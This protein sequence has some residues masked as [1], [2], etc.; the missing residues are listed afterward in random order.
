MRSSSS[1]DRKSCDTPTTT[2][3]RV[4]SHARHAPRA[5][6]PSDAQ[7]PPHHR[8]DA[9]LTAATMATAPPSYGR[10]AQLPPYHGRDAPMPTMPCDAQRQVNTLTPDQYGKPDNRAL[11]AS[12]RRS[13]STHFRK[14][15]SKQSAPNYPSTDTTPRPRQCSLVC[16]NIALYMRGKSMILQMQCSTVS[17]CEEG[18]TK[19]CVDL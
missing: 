5:S 17:S 14:F 7:R 19:V 1:F 15:R 11:S 3:P 6:H 12:D 16:C 9:P 13:K 10:D 8:R 4:P 2:V 18:K